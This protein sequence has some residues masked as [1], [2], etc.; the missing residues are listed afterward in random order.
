MTPIWELEVIQQRETTVFMTGW[1]FDTRSR[2]KEL[3]LELVEPGGRV[4]GRI[5]LAAGKPRPD[6]KAAHPQ[7]PSS[8]HSGFVAVGAWPRRPRSSDQLRIAGQLEDGRAVEVTIAGERWQGAFSTQGRWHRLL[9]GLRTLRY[10]ARRAL[11]LVAT[12]RFGSLRE[13]VSRQLAD[14]PQA[15]LPTPPAWQALLKGPDPEGGDPETHLIVDHRLGGGA[16]QYRQR[17]VED[18]RDRGATVLVLT[19]H[20]ASLS[21]MLLV[22]TAQKRLRF[23]LENTSELLDA[24]ADHPLESITYNTAVSFSQAESIPAL[25]VA[26]KQQSG[27]WLTVLLH[28]YFS[29][30]PSHFLLDAD[31][32]FCDI[33]D[34][35]TCRRCLPRNPHGFT[36][37]Y[38]GDIET[39]RQAWAPLIGSADTILAFS[40]SSAQLL[41]RA[42]GAVLDDRAIQ[43]RP[44]T[45]NYLQA[46]RITRPAQDQFTIG[47]V[48]QIGFHKGS[49]V[50]RQLAEAIKHAGGQERIVVIGTLESHADPTILRQTGPYTHAELPTLIEQSRITVMLIPSIWPETFSFVAEEVMQLDL[51]V[52]CFDLGAPAE[53]IRRYAKGIVLPSRDPDSIL[54]SLHRLADETASSRDP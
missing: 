3:D 31:G 15:P 35:A 27:A 28:D 22:E 8:L 48:G 51:P 45:V 53:R 46:R 42:Y 21:P 16:N 52:A 24:L 37:L 33:P 47:I 41:R 12:G 34:L 6:V 18:L 5:P 11:L 2:T 36:T 7:Y 49:D 50:V 29:I 25:L 17:L 14:R 9:I 19:F 54:E 32:T 4:V 43:V 13:K 39:W 30:C 40:E 10:Y 38:G 20:L 44:H 1:L 26:L 23:S